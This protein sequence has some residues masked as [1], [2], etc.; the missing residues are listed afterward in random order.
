MNEQP[1][2]DDHIHEQQIGF[3]DDPRPR[4]NGRERDQQRASSSTE[5]GLDLLADERTKEV[6]DKIGA[7]IEDHELRIVVVGKTEVGKTTLI[8]ALFED[9][10]QV[11]VTAQR[12]ENVNDRTFDIE[13]PS[14]HQVT[15][16]LTDTPGTE[17]L[18]GVGKKANRRQYVQSVSN[19]IKNA[20][21]VL[22]CLR[23]DD[24]VREQ[25]VETMRFLL[26]EFGDRMWAKVIIVLTFANKV[27]VDIPEEHKQQVF[28]D[29][30]TSMRRGLLRAMQQAGITKEMAEAT[31]V[32]VAGSP[33]NKSLP[34]CDDWVCPFLVNC[35][36]SGVTDNTKAALLHSTWKRWAI[37]TRRM[38]TGTAGGAGVATGLGLVVIGGVMSAHLVGLPLGVPL[39]VVG[40]GITT[41]SASA[42][43]AQTT[44]TEI[45]HSKDMET[46]NKI[47]N[48]QPGDNPQ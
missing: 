42:S 6:L 22:F 19:T 17:A 48:L 35:L 36:K 10:V 4:V 45:K 31:A 46:V 20:D 28:D 29:K 23:M 24:A 3:A 40:T 2:D 1:E 18:V 12:T 27:I 32:C 5:Q 26:K 11:Y 8:S 34:G 16:V 9:N 7:T 41:Y 13:S 15:V 25:E 38:I 44:N 30:F 47:Q 37:S 33:R 43:V 39:I 21:I 14:G